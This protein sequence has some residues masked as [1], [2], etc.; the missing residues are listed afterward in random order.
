MATGLQSKYLKAYGTASTSLLLTKLVDAY[1]EHELSKDPT[2]CRKVELGFLSS[3]VHL[4]AKL[5]E[6]LL[7]EL[8]ASV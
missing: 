6:E 5:L 2:P 8:A 7:V 1:C 3:G 4:Q